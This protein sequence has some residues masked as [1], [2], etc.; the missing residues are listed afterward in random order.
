[1][2][3]SFTGYFN[4]GEELCEDEEVLGVRSILGVVSSHEGFILICNILFISI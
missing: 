1:M 4:C 2:R 3:G